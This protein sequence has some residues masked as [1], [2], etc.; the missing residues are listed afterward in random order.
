MVKENIRL[1]GKKASQIQTRKKMKEVKKM[2]GVDEDGLLGPSMGIYM[3]GLLYQPAQSNVSF[4]MAE[5]G[6]SRLLCWRTDYWRTSSLNRPEDLSSLAAIRQPHWVQ[7]QGEC[8]KRPS[9]VC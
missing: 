6:S 1:I 2:L 8:W 5:R 9:E 4:L 7:L 3:F